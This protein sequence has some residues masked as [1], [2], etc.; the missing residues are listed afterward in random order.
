MGDGGQ[1]GWGIE[2]SVR[3]QANS[4]RGETPHSGYGG[5]A[6]RCQYEKN[7]CYKNKTLYLRT[8]GRLSHHSG[9]C[10]RRRLQPLNKN[11]EGTTG[12][13]LPLHRKSRIRG[14]SCGRSKH[15]EP[16]GWVYHGAVLRD[17]HRESN[18]GSVPSVRQDVRR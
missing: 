12:E 6:K 4:P 11:T 15:G 5:I 13:G 3:S 8:V 18:P 9:F 7:H 17:L 2:V 16:S 14:E 1:W 10:S